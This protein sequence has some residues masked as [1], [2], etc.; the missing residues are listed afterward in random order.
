MERIKD[1]IDFAEEGWV[2]LLIQKVVD[3]VEVIHFL[4]FHLDSNLSSTFITVTTFEQLSIIEQAIESFVDE[5]AFVDSKAIIAQVKIA[6]DL[7]PI[8]F[9]LNSNQH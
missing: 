1:K 8:N 9:E 4:D 6:I 5:W 3:L 7:E 2:L